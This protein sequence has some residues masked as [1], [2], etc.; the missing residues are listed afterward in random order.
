MTF[1]LSPLL[2]LDCIMEILTMDLPHGNVEGKVLSD[3]LADTG[4]AILSPRQIFGSQVT[5]ST[6]S[7]SNST[8]RLRTDEGCVNELGSSIDC[9]WN[10]EPS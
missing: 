3:P 8:S 10:R 5:S 6:L 7:L 9:F 4:D 2:T 1:D